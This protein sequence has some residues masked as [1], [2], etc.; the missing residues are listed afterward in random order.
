MIADDVLCELEAGCRRSPSLMERRHERSKSPEQTIHI[1]ARALLDVTNSP[2]AVSLPPPPI[3]TVVGAAAAIAAD[4]ALATRAALATQPTTA[5]TETAT[6]TASI[7]TAATPTAVQ[8]AAHAA[9]V[10]CTEAAGVGAGKIKTRGR[11]AGQ[12]RRERWQ[13]HGGGGFRPVQPHGA[14]GSVQ[15]HGAHDCSATGQSVAQKRH[16]VEAAL[17]PHGARGV[18]AV[19]VAAICATADPVALAATVAEAEAACNAEAAA[20]KAAERRAAEAEAAA[21]A[22]AK[23]A[24]AVR[25]DAAWQEGNLTLLARQKAD[26]EQRAERAADAERRANASFN[27]L[28][29]GTRARGG[30]RTQSPAPELECAS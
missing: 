23:D 4:A 29:N 24:A 12:R 19:S 25:A 3:K 8:P 5:A 14:H 13:Q 28:F 10:P 9:I 7:S 17:G 6:E 30:A 15:P 1:A 2:G 11:R 27:R 22:A 20:R 18:V 16:A 21:R 26:V